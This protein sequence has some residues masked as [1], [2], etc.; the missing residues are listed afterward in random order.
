[1]LQRFVNGLQKWPLPLGISERENFFSKWGNK[2][3]FPV[4]N[5]DGD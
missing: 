5:S 2:I 1:M 4:G 3:R